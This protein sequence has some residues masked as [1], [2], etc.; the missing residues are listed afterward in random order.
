MFLPDKALTASDC[1][2][3]AQA[4]DGNDREVCGAGATPSRALTAWSEAGGSQPFYALQRV[5]FHR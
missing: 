3:R 5:S 4:G 1:G 2:R